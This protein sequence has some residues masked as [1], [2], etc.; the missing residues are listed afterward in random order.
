MF[1]VSTGSSGL[2]PAPC[3]FGGL[4]G[5]N[6]NGLLSKMCMFWSVIDFLHVVLCVVCLCVW[7][8]G[9][10]TAPACALSGS[11][12]LDPPCVPLYLKL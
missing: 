11:L 1:P 5:V 7:V 3:F 6:C 4:A 10:L 12:S 8:S 2:K 9:S